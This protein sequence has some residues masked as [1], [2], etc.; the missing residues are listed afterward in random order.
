MGR[1]LASLG[2]NLNFAPV[3]AI[4]SN[5]SNPVIGAR[6]FGTTGEKVTEAALAFMAAMQSEHVLACGKHFPGHGDTDKD[7]HRELPAYP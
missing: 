5:P 6:A 4:H 3:L 7:S 1:E 2:I